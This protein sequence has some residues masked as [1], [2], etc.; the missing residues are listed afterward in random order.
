METR[1]IAL[2]CFVGAFIGS[3]IA[4]QI[5]TIGWPV[6]AIV[7]AFVAY[8]GYNI[9]E[10]V[11]AIPV[12][13]RRTTSWRPDSEYWFCWRKVFCEFFNAGFNILMTIGLFAA[14]LTWLS[15]TMSLTRVIMMQIAISFAMGV[16]MGLMS[17]SAS[18]SG[19]IRNR[20]RNDWRNSHVVTSADFPNF[21]K[22][23]NLM[24]TEELPKFIRGLVVATPIAVNFVIGVLVGICKFTAT[25]F[26][27]IHSELRL[28]CA[29]D[30]ALGTA[31]GYFS[32]NALIGAT[33][34]ALLGVLNYEIITVRVMQ[35]A[36]AKSLFR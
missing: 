33:A 7:G 31:V 30:A 22:Y 2:A 25:L 10:I 24:A 27:L 29:V 23:C 17:A 19:V 8:L 9:E 36:G 28:L 20:E 26:R 3:I 18:M 15:S 4:L 21:F 14:P 34:G 6:G 13:Y 12:A 11:L 1:K 5:G 35:I 32:G 16:F